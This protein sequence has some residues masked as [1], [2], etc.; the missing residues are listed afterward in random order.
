[1]PKGF[2]HYNKRGKRRVISLKKTIYGLHQIPRAF[3]NY[4]TKKLIASGVIQYNIDTCFFIGDK[5]TC[6]VYVEDL[7]FWAKD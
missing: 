5:F 1:M 4:L 7:I 3:W 6:I 2:K